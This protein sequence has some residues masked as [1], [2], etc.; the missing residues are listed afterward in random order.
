MLTIAT[1]PMTPET[2]RHLRGPLPRVPP[3]YDLHLIGLRARLHLTEKPW[4]TNGR[5]AAAGLPRRCGVAS[6][7]DASRRQLDGQIDAAAD[8]RLDARGS[9][10]DEHRDTDP[11]TRSSRRPQR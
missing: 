9:D 10:R 1:I 3:N 4:S 8:H 7:T 11:M 2:L 5:V 6:K